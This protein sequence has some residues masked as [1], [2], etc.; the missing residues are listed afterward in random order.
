MF[1]KNTNN[2]FEIPQED[3]VIMH[4]D[5]NS[6]FATCEQQANPAWRGRPLGV[7]SYL[8]PKGT[9]IAASREAKEIGIGTGTKV[10]EAKQLCP[11]IVLV[12]DDP[13]KY[14][15][16]TERI[17]AIFNSYTPDVENYSI[18]ESFLKF[19]ISN[20]KNKFPREAHN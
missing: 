17:Q 9:I 12:R 3:K 11:D 13:T 16:I 6:Y 5:M 10:W 18:D 20:S 2:L 15:V 7:V 1:K 19:P 8:H 4:I 14:R